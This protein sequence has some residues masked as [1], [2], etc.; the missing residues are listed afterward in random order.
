MKRYVD[1]KA[2]ALYLRLEDSAIVESE[3]V[4]PGVVFDYNEENQV[5]GIE[6]LYLSKQFTNLYD[7]DLVG[8]RSKPISLS[9][10]Q[11]HVLEGLRRVETE[12]Y[13]LGDWYLG[14]LYAL[15]NPN[16]PDRIS[17]AAQ[18]LRELMEKLPR[19]L[20]QSN[21]D[22]YM[23]GSG[24][25]SMRE[26]IFKRLKKAKKRYG[27]VFK[28][29]EIDPHLDKTLRKIY[30]YM[31]ENK[32]P[33]RKDQIQIAIKNIDP[34]ADQIGDDI[35]DMKQDQFHTLWKQLEK[36]AHHKPSIN[37]DEQKFRKNL[38]TLEQMVYDLLAPVTAHDQQEIQTIMERTERS[39]ADA[40][41]LYKLIAK[42][43]ANYVFFFT[44]A[45]DSGWIPFLKEKGFFRNPPNVVHLPDGDV[46]YPSW[47][48]L[49]YLKN[50]SKDATEEVIKM[51]LQLPAVDNPNVY[52]SILDIALELEGEHSARLKPKILEY[53]E[54]EHQFLAPGFPKLLTHWTTENQTEAALELTKI[55]LKFSPYQQA[56]D[57]LGLSR[58]IQK[59][60]TNS[61][62]PRPRFGEWEFKQLLNKG[63]RPLAE[64][65]PYR[66]A[67]ML[68]DA[69]ASMISL[70]SRQDELKK[71][72]GNDLSMIWCKRVKDSIK[73]YQNPEEALVHA[74]TFVCK[75][76]YAK[77][78][79]AVPELDQDLRNQRWD[80]FTRIRQHLYAL[81]PNEQTKPW[82]R[83]SI[84]NYKDYDKRK[85]H[86]EFQRMIR[87]GCENFGSDLFSEAEKKQIF[88]AILSG[89]SEQDFRD[90]MGD[91]F[92]EELFEKRK[93]HFHRVQLRP[94]ASVLLGKYRKYFT[95]LKSEEEQQITDDNYGPYRSEGP[96]AI[97]NCSPKPTEELKKLSDEKLL[98]FL[99]K[100]DSPHYDPQK[101]WV[102]ISFSG[103]SQAFQSIFKELIIPDDSRLKFWIENRA[104]LERP[105]YVRTMVSTIRELIEYKE[106][107]KLDQWFDLCEWILTRPDQPKEE[108][109]NPSDKSKEY[110]DWESS[111]RAVGDFI[112]MCLT[113]EVNVPFSFRA[114]IQRLLYKLCTQYDRRLDDDD[115]VLLNKHDQYTEAINTTRGHTLERLVIFAQWVR[116]HDDSEDVPEV[117]AILEKRFS[118]EAKY[119]LTP[120]E[121]AILGR[122]YGWI[123]DLNEEW[124][125]ARKSDIF[126]HSNL[127]AWRE[128]FGNF[129]RYNSPY[130]PIYKELGD[131]FEFSLEHLDCLKPQ[132]DS[133]EKSAQD[134]LGHHLFTY[135]LWKIYPLKDEKSLLQLYYQK[136][137]NNRKRWATLFGYIGRELR[138]TRQLDSDFKERILAFFE[139]RLEV[140]ELGEL[141]EFV[142]WLEADCLEPEWRLKAYSRI[143]DLLRDLDEDPWKG[144]STNLSFH[145][146]L[147]MR[148]M[149]PMCADGVVECFAKLVD[150][151]SSSGV[152][153]IHT[154]DAKA[155]LKAGLEHENEKVR[156]KAKEARENM[157]HRGYLTVM[158]LDN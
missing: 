157:L 86:F 137:E 138:N 92:T 48:E 119:P 74:L 73:D 22:I 115:S 45:M 80:I 30:R 24:F 4:S 55:L 65:E 134:F 112:G 72:G 85:Y 49:Q 154:D 56:D 64:R 19:V 83:E 6:L 71:F 103:L 13:R 23:S 116:R 107:D 133:W 21:I 29:Q 144:E 15:E 38:G 139:W 81:H 9:T 152:V 110:P 91:R 108:G 101:P 5:A 25:Q 122:L 96:K 111:R 42:K 54:L 156:E 27:K 75:K 57:K 37:T 125:I 66:T 17:Q 35:Q 2:D 18:S 121:Y 41:S 63:V 46:Q 123:F 79:E 148:E 34:M 68:I 95:K 97:Q 131:I 153:Q 69:T 109:V 158:D 104:R 40:K 39:D 88:E 146:I 100:W 11:R 120:P 126:P 36:F 135:Y 53:A 10:L 149:L 50:V 28:G 118:S 1:G 145:A 32:K 59:V 70:Q 102:N 136:T 60:W 84:L 58:A 127:P 62:G 78:P 113:Q 77:A 130:R 67:R 47:P 76:V 43:G 105:I 51:V 117:K 16:N 106:F 114:Q 147:S 151:I 143:L 44:N 14:A 98:S 26:G 31:E 3:E 12:E 140:G 33:S 52:N 82:I 129:L 94:F 93:R 142:N 7:D 141:Q 87:L 99:N 89:P 132:M 124:A 20:R 155:I 150:S 61:G 128:A 90:R 8:P